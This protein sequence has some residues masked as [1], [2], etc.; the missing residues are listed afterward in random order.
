MAQVLETVIAIN[1]QVGNGFAAVGTQLTQL[2]A[3]VNGT[4]Q[5]LLNFGK[6]SVEVYKDYEKSLADAEVALSTIYGRNTGELT[7]VMT[8]LDS[9]AT[10]WAAS[11]IFHTND[12][13]NAIS[14]AAH[15]GWDLDK[16]MSGIPAAMELAQAGSLDLSQ[17]VD[18]IVKSTNA[19]GIEF[20]DVGTFIDHWA[21][22]ANSSATNIEELG[23][24]MLRMGGTMKFADNTDELLTMLAVTADAGYTGQ[25]AGTLLRNSML[26]L[27]AP[28]KKAREA[29][30]ELGATSSETAEIMGDEE[31]A[32]ANARLA[33]TGFSAYDEKGNLKGMLDTYRDLYVALGEVAGGY[34]KITENEDSLD[35][36]SAIF[37]TRSITGALTLLEAASTGYK[38]LYEE[39]QTGAAEGYGEYAAGVEMDTLFGNVETFGSKIERLKQLVG[40]ELAPGLEGA[41]NFAGEIVDSLAQL[42]EGPFSALVSGLEVVAFAGPGLLTAGGAL[43]LIGTIIGGKAAAIGMGAIA[44]TSLAAA[45]ADLSETQFKGQFGENTFDLSEVENYVA[46]LRENFNSARTEID[47]YKRLLDEATTAYQEA[48]KSLSS[49]LITKAVTGNTLTQGDKDKFI[50]LGTDIGQSLMGGIQNSFAGTYTSLSQTFGVGTEDQ[51]IDQGMWANIADLLADDYAEQEARIKD[52]SK[53]LVEAMTSAF[54]DDSVTSKE[55]EKIQA[56]FDQ[57]NEIYANELKAVHAQKQAEAIAKAQALG[58]DSAQEALDM[59][60]DEISSELITLSGEQ[61]YKRQKLIN[62]GASEEQLAAFDA[63]ARAQ[64]NVQEASGAS[65]KINTFEALMRG[66]DMG[67]AYDAIRT[68]AD[69]VMQNGG[70]VTAD[71]AE[72]LTGSVSAEEAAKVSAGINDLADRLGGYEHMEELYRTLLGRSDE[73]SQDAAEQIG[74]ALAVLQSANVLSMNTTPTGENIAPVAETIDHGLSQVAALT[75]S[76]WNANTQSE[77]VPVSELTGWSDVELQTAGILGQLQELAEVNLGVPDVQEYLRALTTPDYEW[78][79]TGPIQTT[80]NAEATLDSATLPEM[81]TVP[82]ELEPHIDGGDPLSELR[83]QGIEVNIQG[84]DEQL[85]GVINSADGQEITTYLNADAENIEAT[86]QNEEGKEITFQG[87]V[88][89]LEEELAEL[90]GQTISFNIVGENLIAPQFDYTAV[91]EDLPPIPMSIEPVVESGVSG[92]S[93]IEG[94]GVQVSVE[95]DTTQLQGAISANDAQQL[96]EIVN[97]DNANLS[98]SI[99]DLDGQQ[100]TTIVGGDT[101]QAQEAINALGNQT[102]YINVVARTAG[103]PQAFAEGGRAEQPSIFGEAGPE[104]AIPEE[105]TEHTRQLLAKAAEASGFSL[106]ELAGSSSSDKTSSSGSDGGSSTTIVYSPTINAANVEG[107]ERALGDDKKAFLKYMK[108]KLMFDKLEVYS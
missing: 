66:S 32:A 74:T 106:L 55:L 13:G 99:F 94:E 89:Q 46:G 34:D 50:Q 92:L 4:S 60:D 65:F 2:G 107:V 104:W 19:A 57:M 31:L 49:G 93:E 22:A 51:M 91:P 10:E 52:L 90:D 33:A 56:Y 27:I 105:H 59:V 48:T 7:N 12:V 44:I 18:Y 3:L 98:A 15:A 87:N 38:G 21:Y 41:M 73:D 63:A 75:E 40:E 79:A 68:F 96:I 53:G 103:V 78:P 43:R 76:L 17:A 58:W 81:G 86:I 108:E 95:G 83:D 88:A 80:V 36:L 23:D 69:T 24:A 8:Q 5:T 62:A 54:S 85:I 70:I 30:Q 71:A 84:N 1:A 14:E 6:E 9:A 28:T 64:L 35:I 42:D 97:G 29:M 82:V 67:D 26:R 16:I 47:E 25:E 37:P 20:D 77:G 11:T 45:L 72:Q 101:T 102:V 61:A 39:L 100:I